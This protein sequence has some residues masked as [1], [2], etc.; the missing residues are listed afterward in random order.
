MDSIN[1]SQV[2][3]MKNGDSRYIKNN[4]DVGLIFNK[5]TDIVHYKGSLSRPP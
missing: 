3:G 2:K 4:I 5:I 1:F